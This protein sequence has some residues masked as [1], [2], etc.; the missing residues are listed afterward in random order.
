MC[1][2][3]LVQRE[4]ESRGE[5]GRACTHVQ[6]PPVAASLMSIDLVQSDEDFFVFGDESLLTLMIATS[7][8]PRF[9]L[10]VSPCQ[11][12]TAAKPR[13]PVAQ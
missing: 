12:G 13:N 11:S 6:R 8:L 2:T 3:C 5:A 9:C 4:A 7:S 10:S 1:V